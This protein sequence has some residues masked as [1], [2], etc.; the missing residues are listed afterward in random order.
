MLILVQGSATLKNLTF[1][2]PRTLH[3]WTVLRMVKAGYWDAS[4]LITDW[5]KQLSLQPAAPSRWLPL[6]DRRQDHLRQD[7]RE[8]ATGG[9]YADEQLPAVYL[10]HLPGLTDCA[11]GALSHTNRCRRPGS[12]E[13]RRSEYSVS[14]LQSECDCHPQCLRAQAGCRG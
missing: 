13:E 11:V 12:A 6:L 14:T 7:W 5:H 8:T 2:M 3:Y 10:W 9:L 4:A 1:H